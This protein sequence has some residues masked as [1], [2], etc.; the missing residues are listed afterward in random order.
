MKPNE[1]IIIPIAFG[2]VLVG[3]GIV[4]YEIPMASPK[5][6]IGIGVFLIIIPT[7]IKL[8]LKRKEE[9]K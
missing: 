1:L 7:I 4:W 5:S 8:I 6:L 9:S 2:I 3:T